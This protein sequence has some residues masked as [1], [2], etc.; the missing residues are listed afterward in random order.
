MIQQFCDFTCVLHT[1]LGGRL[2]ETW[3]FAWLEYRSMDVVPNLVR[4]I[5]QNHNQYVKFSDEVEIR[6]TSIGISCRASMFFGP[7]EVPTF[8]QD[9]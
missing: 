9:G 8:V 4:L 7:L 2:N 3:R 6:A 5:R 1:H